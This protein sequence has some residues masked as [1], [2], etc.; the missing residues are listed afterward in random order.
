MNTTRA[1]NH[2]N[3]ISQRAFFKDYHMPTGRVG[4]DNNAPRRERMASS[5][6]SPVAH[7]ARTRPLEPTSAPLRKRSTKRQTVMAA[8]WVKRPISAELDRIAKQ[9]GV[10]RSRV[11]AVLLEEAVHQR[12]H[13]QHAVLLQP[14]IEQAIAAQL[15]RDRARFAAL[16]VRIAYDANTTRHLVGNILGRQD[17][18]TPEALDRIRDWCTRKAKDS[19]TTRTPQIEELIQAVDEW[20]AGSGEGSEGAT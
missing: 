14:I 19:I 10:T 6:P 5:E 7:G 15:Q 16:L 4:Q 17:G 2:G 12:L 13:V 8:G 20:L 9:E 1:Q 11:I 18:V 3:I